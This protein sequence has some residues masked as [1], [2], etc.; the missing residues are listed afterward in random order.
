MRTFFEQ[1]E[2]CDSAT[3]ERLARLMRALMEKQLDS[4]VLSSGDIPQKASEAKRAMLQFIEEHLSH[5]ELGVD[6][7]V[8]AFATSRA[9]VYRTLEDE[10]GIARYITRRRLERALSRLVFDQ[11]DVSIGQVASSLGFSDQGYFGKLFRQHFGISPSR[12]RSEFS[13]DKKH[14]DQKSDGLLMR[15]LLERSDHI[16]GA[17]SKRAQ[18]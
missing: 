1:R 8:D 5:P 11:S 14:I 12:A 6:Q 16:A 9:V 17:A 13:F 15:T 3:A 10:G 7:L 18:N 2:T 4:F